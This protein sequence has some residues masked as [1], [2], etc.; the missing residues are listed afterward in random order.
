MD[1]VTV[2]N[3]DSYNFAKLD[4]W[5]GKT[6]KHQNYIDVSQI[7]KLIFLFNFIVSPAKSL[8]TIE[9]KGPEIKVICTNKRFFDEFTYKDKL[10]SARHYPR[11]ILNSPIDPETVSTVKTYS[12]KIRIGKHSKS[13]GNKFNAEHSL[14]INAL[15]NKYKDK[16]SWDFMGVPGE[17]RNSIKNIINVTLRNEYA[18]SVKDYLMGI[19]IFMFFPSWKRTEPWARVIAEGMMSGCPIIATNKGGNIEQVLHQN[20]GFLCESIDDFVKYIS[21]LIENPGKIKQMGRNSRI[22]SKEFSSEIIIKKFIDFVS[23]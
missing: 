11:M 8:P 12:D 13:A 21:Y 2:I 7:K 22:Y 6:E 19:D 1:V 15:N 17:F 16:I 9:A 18:L 14:L 20:N 10:I 3:S 4:Y 23:Q 5:E